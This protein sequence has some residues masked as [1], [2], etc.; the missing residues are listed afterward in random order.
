MPHPSCTPHF[1]GCVFFCACAETGI[2]Y[3]FRQRFPHLRWAR[4]APQVFFY[5]FS[6][7]PASLMGTYFVDPSW[8]AGLA[9]NSRSSR[10]WGAV[11][12]LPAFSVGTHL[13]ST[14]QRR[15]AAP[16]SHTHL[17]GLLRPRRGGLLFCQGFSLLRLEGGDENR[18][19]FHRAEK[20]AGSTSFSLWVGFQRFRQQQVAA[21]KSYR[22]SHPVVCVFSCTRAGAGLFLS[23]SPA[24]PRTFCRLWRLFS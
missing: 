9:R 16:K 19:T 12:F 1:V 24:A 3:L 13:V 20:C 11:L 22:I 18:A 4:R 14:S 5:C 21:P 7:V 17:G 15:A 10:S 6:I 23:T 2:G 8:Q